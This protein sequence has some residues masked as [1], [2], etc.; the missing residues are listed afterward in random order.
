MID[1][2]D[3]EREKRML[4]EEITMYLLKKAALEA[5][6]NAQ[7]LID[8]ETKRQIEEAYK[9][10]EQKADRLEVTIDRINMR[11]SRIEES[12][13]N[14]ENWIRRISEEVEKKDID[15]LFGDIGSDR[16]SRK[17]RKK[18]SALGLLPGI[19][20]LVVILTLIVSL[21]ISLGTSEKVKENSVLLSKG[22]PAEAILLS[23]LIAE[24]PKAQKQEGKNFVIDELAESTKAEDKT[25]KKKTVPLR[26]QV[27]TSNSAEHKKLDLYNQAK[28]VKNVRERDITPFIKEAR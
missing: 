2:M 24:R 25:S 5:S 8:K 14:A 17:K 26:I 1:N 15:R 12:L 6:E 22:E 27:Q 19:F 3:F 7:R 10:M 23:D 11:L 28:P 16:P 20:V 13:S 9:E 4:D 21:G 18:K